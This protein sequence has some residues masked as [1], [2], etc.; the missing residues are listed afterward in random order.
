MVPE[1]ESDSVLALVAALDPS[2]RARLRFGIGLLSLSAPVDLCSMSSGTSLLGARSALRPADEG[3]WHC[4][5]E[6]E[7]AAFRA[8]AGGAHLPSIAEVESQGRT[9]VVRDDD[10]ERRVRTRGDGVAPY[11]EDGDARARR[12]MPLAIGSAALS[13]VVLAFALTMWSRRENAAEVEVPVFAPSSDTGAAPSDAGGDPLSGELPKVVEVVEASNGAAAGAKSDA[14][15]ESPKQVAPPTGASASGGPQ[16]DD[17]GHAAPEANSTSE[18]A[19]GGSSAPAETTPPSQDRNASGGDPSGADKESESSK[20]AEAD[21]DRSQEP[22]PSGALRDHLSPDHQ[23]LYRFRNAIGTLQIPTAERSESPED[24]SGRRSGTGLDA[25]G[26][27]MAR[28]RARRQ[29]ASIA[30]KHMIEA[31]E[32][33]QRRKDEAKSHDQ[34]IDDQIRDSNGFICSLIRQGPPGPSQRN[35]LLNAVLVGK[36]RDCLLKLQEKIEA[37]VGSEHDAQQ[38]NQDVEQ[39]LEQRRANKSQGKSASPDLVFQGIVGEALELKW[40]SGKL[41]HGFSAEL[42]CT[43]RVEDESTSP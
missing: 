26:Y 13:T 1:G 35:D 5:A 15:S 6:S 32:I 27:S 31:I 41:T 3:A 39:E 11:S 29:L 2:D 18:V 22:D 28:A 10:D 36:W 42:K 20:P 38:W 8:S 4:G 21:L 7:Y 37:L 19:K 14:E 23:S 25:Q 9:L 24:G 43:A 30:V 17:Q 12:L 40:R 33:D 16:A 34:T